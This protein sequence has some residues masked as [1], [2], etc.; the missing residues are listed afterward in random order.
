MRSLDLPK[1]LVTILDDDGTQCEQ[2]FELDGGLDCLDAIDEAVENF[3]NEA[4]PKVEQHLLQ[5]AQQRA[6]AK[7]KKKLSPTTQRL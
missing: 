7:Q 4:L 1:I 6:L 5:Q 2:S 3:K